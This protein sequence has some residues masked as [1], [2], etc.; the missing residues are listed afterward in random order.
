MQLELDGHSSGV[1]IRLDTV[2]IT[3]KLIRLF[4][5]LSSSCYMINFSGS[6]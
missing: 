1:F 4:L 2:W 6:V 3:M 5:Q